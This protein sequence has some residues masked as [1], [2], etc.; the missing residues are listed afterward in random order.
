M[1]EG[2][3]YLANLPQACTGAPQ[4][5]TGTPQAYAGMPQALPE[6]NW[7]DN[8]TPSHWDRI[9]QVVILSCETDP[10]S[11]SEDHARECHVKTRRA[12]D[13]AR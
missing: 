13:V 5:C 7:V 8:P 1:P 3:R 10:D 6:A 11:E 2:F 12:R 4:A 9:R